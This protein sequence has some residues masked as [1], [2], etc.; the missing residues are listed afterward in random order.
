MSTIRIRHNLLRGAVASFLLISSPARG[1]TLETVS[2]QIGDIPPQRVWYSDLAR[3]QFAV[4]A[5]I[6]GDNPIISAIIDTEDGILGTRTYDSEGS[7]F[8]YIP[9]PA[10]AEEF[11]VSFTAE[12][13]GASV[14]Q[15]VS[16]TPLRPLPPETSVFGLKPKGDLPDP[17]SNEFL[18]VQTEMISGN[19]FF[20]AANRSSLRKITVIGKTVVFEDGHPNE[21]WGYHDN[22]DIQSMTIHAETMVIRGELHLPQTVLEIYATEIRF[23]DQEGA[24]PSTLSTEPRSSA[25][26]PAKY[27][28]GRAG[29]NAGALTI[30]T[31]TVTSAGSEPRFLLKGGNGERAGQG[32][33]GSKGAS[34]SV[35]KQIKNGIYKW[36]W[37]DNN[38]IYAH[39]DGTFDTTAGS[40]T[41]PGNGTNARSGGKPGIAG[42]GGIITSNLDL[43]IL[44]ANPGGTEGTR[45]SYV[46]GGGGG[47]PRPAY[48]R[49]FT[50]SR[51]KPK[52]THYSSAGKSYSGP[53]SVKVNGVAPEPTTMAGDLRWL[54]PVAM[55]KV[56]IYFNQ[57]YLHQHFDFVRTNLDDYI[58]LI[59]LAQASDAWAD[60]E[61]NNR[62]DLTQILDELRSL[63]HRIGS[64][65]DYFGNPAGWVPMLSFE[66]NK[67]AFEN[68]IP[69]AL[70]VMYLNYWLG[71]KADTIQDKI[72]AMTAMRA[73]LKEDLKSDRTEYQQVVATIP[74]L[75]FQARK[76]Q[77]GIDDAKVDIETLKNSLLDKAKNIALLKK[78]AKALGA[79]AEIFPVG[80]PYVGLAGSTLSQIADADPDKPLEE[81]VLII[82][83]NVA[84]NFAQSKMAEKANAQK[85]ASG[86]LDLD[87]LEAEANAQQQQKMRE[88]QGPI[89]DVLGESL[90]QIR[91]SQ[92]PSPEVEAEL[93]RLLADEPAYKDLIREIKKLNRRKS[94]FTIELAQTMQKVVN[95]TLS[96]S[97]NLLIVDILNRNIQ[98]NSLVL[99]AETLSYLGAMNQRARDRLLKY[100]YFMARAYE[101]RMLRPYDGELDLTKIFDKFQELATAGNTPDLTPEQFESLQAVYEEQISSVVFT[102]LEEYNSNRP[103]LSAPVRV[104]LSQSI[105]DQLNAGETA[106]LNL[107]DERLFLPDQ[108]NLRIVD[109]QVIDLQ[110][111][112][113]GDKNDIF[114]SDIIF[115]HSGVSSLQTEGETYLFRHYN[116]ETRSK[117]EWSSRFDPFDSSLDPVRP[118]AAEQS[119]LKSLLSTGSSSPSTEDLLL[120]SRPAAKADLLMTKQTNSR[121][122]ADLTIT[123]MR[124]ELI[125]DFSRKNEQIKTLQVVGDPEGAQPLVKLS[126]GDLNERQNGEGTF[127]RS[128][129]IGSTVV[130][131]VPEKIGQYVFDGWKGAGVTDPDSPVTTVIMNNNTEVQPQYRAVVPYVIQV[132]GGTGSGT[133]ING[134]TINIAAAIPEGYRFVKWEGT[135]VADPSSPVTTFKVSSDSAIEAVYAAI[136]AI[137]TW[138]GN[139]SA[140]AQVGTGA[141]VLIPGFVIEGDVPKTVL[142]RAI[143]PKLGDFGVGGF[144][145]DPIV[146]VFN[147]AN[148]VIATNDNWGSAANL[149]E[150]L[151]AFADT[152]AFGLSDG[153]KDAS[154]LIT[155]EPGPYT[156]KVSGV[157]GTIGVSLVEVYDADGNAEGSRLVNISGRAQVGTGADVLIPGFVVDGDE[158]KQ[159]LIRAVGPTLGGLG[160]AGVLENPTLTVFQGTTE[161]I[162]NDDWQ[163]AAN[164]AELV[165]VSSQVGAFALDDGSADAAVLITLDSGAYTIKVSGVGDTTGVALVEIYEVVQP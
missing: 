76:V 16:I 22:E 101:Y 32:S 130:L 89:M 132:I 62:N 163:D 160:V 3:I 113:T 13:D 159:Y 152:G 87:D 126:K 40:K 6:L 94:D 61:E 104:S 136:K 161:I 31:D 54:S 25:G 36:S 110:V 141:N 59:E 122:G 85:V 121:F 17:E 148:E 69:R 135:G 127:D 162:T 43:S 100:H 38:T 15:T 7:V 165:T 151:S 49:Y 64:N 79:V 99:D 1:Q 88:L 44:A 2:F 19:V 95:L 77:E 35:V 111:E 98:E 93:Q 131:E 28:Q 68:E 34:R 86:E 108:E 90:N 97:K 114:Y 21:L 150:M 75:E 116:D 55:Q 83:T 91:N 143:G 63:K 45:A 80:Q 157:G 112:F 158:T 147:A 53:A 46:S 30:F 140:R 164:L 84:G 146:Q 9:D 128:F 125:Y 65:L 20:N 124:I 123:G 118:S 106:K 103:S 81:N 109:L 42:D 52:E 47:T 10:D 153:S 29:H 115:Q 70:R 5:D 56:L 24:P 78:T 96:I 155:L 154:A 156:V 58:E 14:A 11:T 117:I 33:T 74:G 8:T 37:T 145:V 149:A 57:A 18:D 26:Q 144:L 139:I 51:E 120:Y 4:T 27:A 137:S 82:G 23:E 67:L 50:S 73:Q 60:L 134:E 72:D 41:W 71:N 107:Y 105:L 138:L 12:K 133:Y 39:F 66:V 102:I 129:D 119:L 142:V 48:R 92:S